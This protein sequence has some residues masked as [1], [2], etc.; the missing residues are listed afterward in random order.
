MIVMMI[1]TILML[2]MTIIVIL[3]MLRQESLSRATLKWIEGF[4]G[5]FRKGVVKGARG[6]LP[7]RECSEAVRPVSL[8]TLWISEGLT[9]A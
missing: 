9:Q 3:E 1:V 7:S 5:G 4:Q 2:L 6:G 8:L